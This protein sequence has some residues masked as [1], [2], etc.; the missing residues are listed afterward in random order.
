LQKNIL[1]NNEYKLVNRKQSL[2]M[3]LILTNFKYTCLYSLYKVC[4][5]MIKTILLSLIIF[6]SCTKEQFFD[7]IVCLFSKPINAY[8]W[9]ISLKIY[10]ATSLRKWLLIF[11]DRV[12]AFVCP[13]LNM[14]LPLNVKW[15]FLVDLGSV[16]FTWLVNYQPNVA[17]WSQVNFCN[18]SI[19]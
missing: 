14:Y 7:F 16:N 2:T 1:S 10:N 3:V 6:Y 15:Q 18:T 19:Q 8:L 11:R 5:L 12:V 13:Q 9:I 4:T 17:L